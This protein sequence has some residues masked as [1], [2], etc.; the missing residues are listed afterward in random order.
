MKHK[1]AI[2]GATAAV[3]LV[4][5]GGVAMSALA[6]A[7]DTK[8]TAEQDAGLPQ[9]TAEVEQSDLT[10]T[11]QTKGTLGFTGE[12]KVNASAPGVLTWLAKTGAAVKR[13]G[14]LYEVNGKPVY[15]LYGSKPMYRELKQGAEGEDVRQLKENLIALGYGT[16][17][18]A[19]DEFTKGTAKGLKAWQKTHGLKQTGT[20]GPDHIAFVPGGVRVQGAE[21]AVGAL[22]APGAPVLS[23]TGSERLVEFE[24]K[25]KDASS[26]KVGDKVTVDLPDGSKAKGQISSVGKTV[27][28]D[29]GPQGGDGTPKVKIT[30]DLDDS[31]K[32]KG[33]DKAPVT[34]HLT[35]ETRKNA[36]HVPVNA[37]LADPQG[38]FAVQVVEGSSV[39]DVKV[40][41]G[42]FANGQV[43]ISGSGVKAGMKVGVPK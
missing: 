41:L 22:L 15:L 11:S 6:D 37:L 2:V 3:V 23:T 8:N 32:V 25:V 9:A 19:D 17:L 5:C 40:E 21:A 34:V 43:Q 18:A 29:E 27:K 10:S 4:T 24:L 38:G 14:K 7:D 28:A 35:G 20:V 36:L 33:V 26:L 12:R 42:L 31:E 16:G 1:K 39:R 30:V 13:G